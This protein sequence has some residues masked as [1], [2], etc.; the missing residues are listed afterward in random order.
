MSNHVPLC[1]DMRFSIGFPITINKLQILNWVQL[2]S[3]ETINKLLNFCT[4]YLSSNS[5]IIPSPVAIVKSHGKKCQNYFRVSSPHNS[6]KYIQLASQLASQMRQMKLLEKKGIKKKIMDF[7]YCGEYSRII[8]NKILLCQI[9]IQL[10][11]AD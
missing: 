7:E 9:F 6:L 2:E 5:N 10:T 8:L 11:F 1:Q 3:L 4:L